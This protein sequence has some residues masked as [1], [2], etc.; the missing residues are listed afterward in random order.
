MGPAP[1]PPPAADAPAAEW[2]AWRQGMRRADRAALRGR[3]GRHPALWRRVGLPDPAWWQAAGAAAAGDALLK[4]GKSS[5]VV[6][7]T[8]PTGEAVI[9][10]HYLPTRRLDPRDSLGFSKAMRSL[11]AAE[12]LERRGFDV[13]RPWA[14]W[15]R[16]GEG[17]WLLLEDL[18]ETRPLHEEVLHHEGPARA[19][20]LAALADTLR[21][22]HRSGVAYRDLKPSNLMVGRDDDA[23]RFHFVDHDR[24]RFSS[25][26]VPRRIALRDLA[27]VHAGLPPAV[28][29]SERMAALRRYEPALAARPAWER[30][31]PPVLAEAAARAHRWVPHG[32]LG[33]ACP[34]PRA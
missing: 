28:R 29:A 3:R 31:I 8:A 13:A 22:L 30:D 24:N 12:A 7:L 2:N 5:R 6:R 19:A 16:P 21:R 34:P 17:S 11:L 18:A 20:L 10:K 9:L 23:P 25:R 1:S 15:S 33:A 32:L 26:E 27:A 14:C 4:Q